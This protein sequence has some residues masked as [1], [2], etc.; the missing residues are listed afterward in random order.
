[1]S[2]AGRRFPTASHDHSSA[3]IPLPER[4]REPDMAREASVWVSWYL[5]FNPDSASG[6]GDTPTP[7]RGVVKCQRNGI[8]LG[9]VRPVGEALIL[10]LHDHEGN[11]GLNRFRVLVGA[12]DSTLARAADPLKAALCPLHPN[13]DPAEQ[14]RAILGKART[15]D[16]PPFT[17][18]V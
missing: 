15:L 1:M 12:R 16:G 7:P 14:V 5:A 6:P 13:R 3:P 9:H 11:D 8:F 18:S 4:L 17:V 2:G 10:G